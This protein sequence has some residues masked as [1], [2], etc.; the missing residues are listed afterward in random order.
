M[1]DRCFRTF[2]QALIWAGAFQMNA[3]A[4]QERGAMAPKYPASQPMTKGL[5]VEPLHVYKLAKYVP[6]Y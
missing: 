1:I 6:A 3:I 4:A 2:M 5:L